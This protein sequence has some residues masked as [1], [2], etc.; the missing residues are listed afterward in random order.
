[1]ERQI[2]IRSGDEVMTGCLYTPSNTAIPAPGVV[3]CHGFAGQTAPVLARA[4]S[5][6][7]YV[8][9]VFMFRG[10]GP[11]RTEVVNVAPEKQVEDLLAA[12]SFLAGQEEVD[13]S[14]VGVVGSSLG[15]S[16]AILGAA[17]DERLKVCV[18][19]C[20]IGVGE[21]WLRA[22]AGSPERW[23][24]IRLSAES[25]RSA[26]EPLRRFDIVP[27][28][29]DLQ[30]HLP[31]TTP[32]LFTAD[33]FFALRELNVETKIGK[34]QPRSALVLH[35]VDDRVVPPSESD[36]LAIVAGPTTEYR[37]LDRGDHFIT[38]DPSAQAAILDW[39]QTKLP[40]GPLG[41]NQK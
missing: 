13:E 15:G 1:M 39:L 4:L 7:G 35:A 24:E 17:S 9:L 33:T 21:R 16:I 6:A 29:E 18:A 22:I 40:L 38:A 26:K 25:A 8:A 11:D 30:D 20:P 2:E 14:R 19:A 34:I 23:R 3:L 5:E 31:E 10:Y 37:V 32:M 41:G 27:I 12:T 28:P 36:E